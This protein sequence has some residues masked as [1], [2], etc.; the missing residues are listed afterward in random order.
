[1]KLDGVAPLPAYLHKAGREAG[2]D[3]AGR[4]CLAGPVC[5]AAVILSPDRAVPTLIR[6][7]K[8]LSAK[9][10]TQAA[11][12]VESHA[13]SWAVAYCSPAE[14]DEMNILKA[15]FAAMHRA[16]DALPEPP[17]R[18]LVD[19]HRFTPYRETP[20]QCVVK[21][22]GKYAHIG[23]ASILAKT[24]RDRFMRLW[25][26]DYPEYQWSSNKGYPTAAHIEAVRNLGITPLHRRSF[27]IKGKQL[28]LNL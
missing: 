9:Q 18:I 11:Q 15:S 10:R 8:Q 19:G 4:G 12:W 27:H 21:G 23:A 2:C 24:Y 7:S 17:D 22:D 26:A 5:A 14:I 20:H 16:L 1:M 13:L 28:K 25:H 3:E 6:D